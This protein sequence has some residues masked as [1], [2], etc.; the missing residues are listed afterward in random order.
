MARSYN[1]DNSFIARDLIKQVCDAEYSTLEV[2][3][4]VKNL[5]IK[6]D[7]LILE[8]P[9]LQLEI[10]KACSQISEHYNYDEGIAT[11][12]YLRA[13]SS[14]ENGN[15]EEAIELLEEALRFFEESDNKIEIAKILFSLGKVH[16]ELQEYDL[17]LSF[18][19]K[20]LKIYQLIDDKAQ[21]TKIYSEIGS[22]F[23]RLKNFGESLGFFQKALAGA[24]ELNDEHQ[25]AYCLLNIGVINQHAQQLSLANGY[26][27]E[28][29]RLSNRINDPYLVGLVFYNQGILYKE[30]KKLAISKAYFLKSLDIKKK[31][32]DKLGVANC[33]FQLGLLATKTQEFQSGRKHL[34]LAYFAFNELC[35]LAEMANCC[36]SIAALFESIEDY[37]SALK[38]EREYNALMQK[39]YENKLQ[40]KF[41]SIDSLNDEPIEEVQIFELNKNQ[42]SLN[43]KNQQLREFAGI[44]SHDLQEP[45][46]SIVSFTAHLKRK[47]GKEIDETA[48]EFMDFIEESGLRMTQMLKDLKD[49]AL[50]GIEDHEL[51]CCDLNDVMEVVR[52]NLYIKLLESKSNL[53]IPSNLPVLLN[54]F[55]CFKTW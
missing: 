9:S 42:F 52:R 34:F 7:L 28:V 33:H 10:V 22:T 48:Q 39:V 46:R 40:G 6:A 54:L 23:F 32:D 24:K 12:K 36:K 44:V 35:N 45:L 14:S 18:L 53:V 47:I 2:Q 50:L 5:S 38:F 16:K 49:Y 30:L 25:L 37:K 11:S 3:E 20:S 27:S 1:I 29:L 13:K 26:F 8:N 21:I 43:Q 55:S 19:F 4:I 15:N 41:V 17:C 51:V 31:C